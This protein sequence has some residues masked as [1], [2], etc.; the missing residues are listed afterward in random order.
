DAQ[1]MLEQDCGIRVS[2][3]RGRQILRNEGLAAKRKLQKPKLKRYLRA[4]RMDFVR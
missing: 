3:A 2:A 1:E 4:E